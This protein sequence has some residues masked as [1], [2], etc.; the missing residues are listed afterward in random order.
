LGYS[1]FAGSSVNVAIGSNLYTVGDHSTAIGYLVNVTEENSTVIGVNFRNSQ[2]NSFMVGWGSKAMVVNSS[3]TW[4]PGGSVHTLGK[5]IELE[6][7]QSK[8]AATAYSLGMTEGSLDISNAPKSVFNEVPADEGASARRKA[9]DVNLAEGVVWNSLQITELLERLK[10]L[11]ESQSEMCK[12]QGKKFTDG[13]V[14]DLSVC[15][16]K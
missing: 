9:V 7:E 16:G 15:N 1:N 6:L 11:E 4:V 10:A 5:D 8:K 2:P 14:L 13:T 3:G 12:Y